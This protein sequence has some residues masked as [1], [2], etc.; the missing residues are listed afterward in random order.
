L[1]IYEEDFSLEFIDLKAMKRTNTGK[2]AARRLRQSDQIPAVLYGKGIDP[3]KLTLATKD[4][5]IIFRKYGRARLFF[6]V[7]IDGESTSRKAFLKELQVDIVSGKYSHMDLHQ[8]SMDQTLRLTVPVET[9][10]QS[11]GVESGGLLQI[12][13]RELEIIC[14]PHNIP[15]NIEVDVT[16]LDIGASIH[17]SELTL[18]EGVTIPD[19]VDFTIITVV[20][21]KGYDE[22]GE[23]E[24]EA[25]EEEGAEGESTESTDKE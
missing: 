13:R 21:P 12:I 11:I 8:I 10:G 18:P 19:D 2:G 16:D 25:E 5:D 14:L 24:E 7:Q 4:L 20:Q 9:T 6:N 3:E 23:E 17:V 1:I 15:N 22:T